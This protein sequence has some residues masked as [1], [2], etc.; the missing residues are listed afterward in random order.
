MS[1]TLQLTA[2]ADGDNFTIVK[3]GTVV[4]VY[5]NQPET[6]TPEST[7]AASDLSRIV[8]NGVGNDAMIW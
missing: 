7:V 3:S 4:N 1:V 5:H 6:G 2:I 8:I